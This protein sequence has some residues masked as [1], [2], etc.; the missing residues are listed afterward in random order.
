LLSNGYIVTNLHVIANTTLSKIYAISPSRTQ[1]T[2]TRYYHNKASGLGL[3]LLKPSTE[4]SGG[5]QL[6]LNCHIECSQ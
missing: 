5:L 2:F 6:D 4:L 1:I 3:V